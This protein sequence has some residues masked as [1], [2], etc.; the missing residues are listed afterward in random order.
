MMMVAVARSD[1]TSS[2]A[3]KRNRGAVSPF[4]EYIS[5]DDEGLEVMDRRVA[6]RESDTRFVKKKKK[7]K[8]KLLAKTL[9]LGRTSSAMR[10]S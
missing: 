10:R 5:I 1:D 4:F 7:K 6:T 9:G 8:K 2:A 3:G